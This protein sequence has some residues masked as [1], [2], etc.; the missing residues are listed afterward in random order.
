MYRD[1]IMLQFD[2]DDALINRE[3][4]A[5]LAALAEAWPVERTLIAL[6]AISDTRETLQRNVSPLLATESLL[7]TISSGR[8]P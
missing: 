2:R 1:V 3:L 7:V 4:Q 6:D 8:T 5:D